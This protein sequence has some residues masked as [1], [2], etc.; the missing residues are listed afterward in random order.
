MTD[1]TNKAL[2]SDAILR[3]LYPMPANQDSRC[4]HIEWMGWGHGSG[5]GEWKCVLQDYTHGDLLYGGGSE[6]TDHKPCNCSD[7]NSCDVYKKAH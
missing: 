2:D 6:N 1:F 4:L 5:M 3:L 7:H